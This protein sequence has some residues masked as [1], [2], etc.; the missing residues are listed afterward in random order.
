MM[1][2]Y[3]IVGRRLP[4][5]A[6][7]SPKLYKMRIFAPNEVV[8]KSRFFYFLRQLK[9][10]KRANGEIVSL[11]EVYEHRPL[12]V[13]NFG[14]WLRYDSRSGT[15]NM[16][17]EYRGMSRVEAVQ[18][19]YQDLAA[20]HRCRFRSIQIIRIAELSS[21]EVRRPYIQQL[22]KPNLKFPLPHRV[23]QAFRPVF[24]GSRPSTF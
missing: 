16:Y 12:K 7:P 15:H 22:L 13:K 21:N 10:I 14:I 3:Q 19:C 8:A 1:H 4:S 5:A 6:E 9:K 2:E 23:A 24:A 18:Q 20:R 11:S 17:K